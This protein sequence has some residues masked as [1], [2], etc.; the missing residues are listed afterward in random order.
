MKKSFILTIFFLLN[1][2]CDENPVKQENHSPIISSLIA[3]PQTISPSDSLIVI[4]YASDP[5]GDTLVY[6]WLTDSRLKIE[7]TDE[8]ILYHTSENI[9]RFY[10]QNI[11]KVPDTLGIT[12]SARDVKGGSASKSVLIFLQPD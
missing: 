10:L 7:G 11:N 6:D 4:C 9:R 1:I 3:F 5:D 2:S 12:C 8:F